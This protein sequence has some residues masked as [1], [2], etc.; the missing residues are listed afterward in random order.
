M[1]FLT[2]LRK[3]MRDH[4]RRARLAKHASWVG[5]YRPGLIYGSYCLAIFALHTL[6][7]M[8]FEGLSAGDGLW[9][10]LTTITTVG[11]GDLSAATWQGRVATVVLVYIGGIFVVAKVVGDFFD[12]RATRREAMNRGNWDWS[13]ERN[14]IVVVGSNYDSEHH[15]TRLMAE[16]ERDEQTAGR[17]IVLLSPAFADGL[18]ASLRAMGVHYLHGSS[19]NPDLLERAGIAAAEIIVV[20]A[21]D[22][23]DSASDG[24]AFDIIHRIRDVNQEAS[25]VVECVEDGNRP[26]LMRAGASLCVRP[27]RAYPEM[28]VNALLQ[29]GVIEILENLF[30]M[31]GEQIGRIEGAVKGIWKEVVLDYVERDLGL[32]IAYQ[33]GSD[34]RVVTAPKATAD[35]DA[36]AIFVL[37]GG[38]APISST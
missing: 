33:N 7:M 1:L 25:V 36:S 22:A 16:F 4:R 31:D 12:Y 9:L 32:P 38:T 6:A 5:V 3:R 21:A 34:G 24:V 26:R 8:Q 30:T 23:R 13:G 2:F 11:Y 28:L 19:A 27:V 17:T 20:L 14:H 18:P 35:I 29:P 15:L 10:T 37:R